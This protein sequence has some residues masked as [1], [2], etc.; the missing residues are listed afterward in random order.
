VIFISN[1]RWRRVERTDQ[2]MELTKNDHKESALRRRSGG[3]GGDQKNAL[4]AVR[5]GIYRA[6]TSLHLSKLVREG[7]GGRK[8]EV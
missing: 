3:P 2:Q 6:G 4:E 8:V 1:K 7:V 5:N